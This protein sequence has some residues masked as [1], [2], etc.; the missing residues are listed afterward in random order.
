MKLSIKNPIVIIA[1]ILII[2]GIVF[3]VTQTTFIG[4]DKIACTKTGSTVWS[5]TAAGSAGIN[6]DEGTN[7]LRISKPSDVNEWNSNMLHETAKDVS[8]DYDDFFKQH[9]LYAGRTTSG[10]LGWYSPYDTGVGWEEKLPGIEMAQEFDNFFWMVPKSVQDR[11]LNNAMITIKG[12]LVE[13]A[14]GT[15]IANAETYGLCKGRACE[16]QKIPGI[17]VFGNPDFVASEIKIHFKEGGYTPDDACQTF[18]IACPPAAAEPVTV[19]IPTTLP[20]D[21]NIPGIVP[22]ITPGAGSTQPPVIVDDSLPIAAIIIP[23]AIGVMIL[24]VVVLV[25]RRKFKK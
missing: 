17:S 1:L 9:S 2:A 7:S 5:C 22:S 20:E 12:Q 4:A 10:S 11:I 8:Q 18:D 14:D 3:G 6:L 19:I 21:I 13:Q 16:I 24:I 23:A 15:F 25:I